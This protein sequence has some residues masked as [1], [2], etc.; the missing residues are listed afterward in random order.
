MGS[1]SIEELQKQFS[2]WRRNKK[3]RGERIPED[4]WN[5]AV[6]LCNS[7]STYQ[8]SRKL[9]L[10]YSE[11]KARSMLQLGGL[12]PRPLEIEESSVGFIQLS[13]ASTTQSNSQ[14]SIKSNRHEVSIQCSGLDFEFA[15]TKLL[16]SMGNF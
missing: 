13:P 2:V 9:S 6:Y 14:I 7:I 12:S 8:V 1:I 3:S 4:L 16:S 5:Q 15:I 11:L 10:S